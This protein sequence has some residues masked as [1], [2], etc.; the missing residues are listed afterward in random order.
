MAVDT[1]H[2][3]YTEFAGKWAK[4]RDAAAGEEAVKARRDEYLPMLKG[5]GK[6]DYAAYLKR[7]PYF[8]ATART[9]DGLSGMIFRRA[10]IISRPPAMDDFVADVTFEGV[11]LAAFAEQVV[12]EVLITGRGGVIVDFPRA[13][14]ADITLA[15]AGRMGR[16]PFLRF[17]RAEDILNWRVG[18]IDNRTVLVQVRLFERVEQSVAGEGE[19]D[20]A[21]VDQ[22]RVLDLV[23][24]QYRQRLFRQDDDKE[25]VPHGD[26]IFPEQGGVP[27]DF[28]PFRF[29]G[30]RDTA[31]RIAK[32]PLLDLVNVNLSHFRSAADLEHGAHFVGLPTPYVFGTA[33][34]PATIGPTVVW[35]APENDVQVGMLE[36]TG[37]GLA[38]LEHLLDRKE[39]QMAVLGARMLFPEKKAAEAA[40]TAS[41]HRQGENSAL[42]ALAQAVARALSE[43]TVIA[44]DWIAASDET[45]IAL[46]TDY[47]PTPMSPQMLVALIQAVQSGHISRRTFFSNLQRGE[48]IAAD[49]A[50]E[51]EQV[52]IE[53]E[54]P[55]V[56]TQTT[57]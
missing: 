9:V 1:P 20:S 44:R 17:Y 42:A 45:G 16:R 10:P 2:P 47:L 19:F 43:A 24:G 37:G 34:A 29:V 8:N 25:W 35:H 30:P 18:S 53:G 54:L 6:D 48:I 38:S 36:F 14:D 26:E 28:L 50:F 33:E 51:D 41:M 11:S 55:T 22:I 15:Q 40:E 39:Q 56:V 5:Q 32:P 4:A 13:A 57:V 27:M 52:E 12:Q 3:E 7:T 49:M 46:N 31:A 23:E 21:L